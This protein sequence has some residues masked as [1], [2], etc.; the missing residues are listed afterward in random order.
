MNGVLALALLLA[1]APGQKPPEWRALQPGVE[2]RA[3]TFLEQPD[4]G[5]GVLH[6]VRVDPA[7]AALQLALAS[8]ARDQATHTCAEWARA[9]GL[10]VAINAGMYAKDGV[11]NVGYLRHDAHE[12]NG[13]WNDYQAALLFGPRAKGL[14]AAQLVDRDAPSFEG[15]PKKY[16]SAVQNLRLIKAPG[17][18]VWQPN[19]KRWSEAALAQDGQGRLLFLFLRSPVQMA[20]FN[21]ALL[22]LPLDVKRAMHL[23]GGPPACF[24]VHGGGVDLDLAGAYETTLFEA[25]A[26]GRQWRLPNVLG[27]RKP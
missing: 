20:D 13:R 24:S 7:R 18:S 23:D 12:N 1:A 6:V 2:Y 5:D 19:D 9:S 17:V 3:F 10:V 25:P 14:P 8:E 21:A 16:G 15:L 27:V 26:D 11:S 4:I 22:A